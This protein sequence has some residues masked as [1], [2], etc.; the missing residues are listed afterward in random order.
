VTWWPPDDDQ[1]QDAHAVFGRGLSEEQV[2]DAAAA[3]A[4]DHESAGIRPAGVPDGFAPLATGSV[5]FDFPVLNPSTCV[6]Y[7]GPG[8]GWITLIVAEGDVRSNSWPARPC[9]ASNG[10]SAVSSGPWAGRR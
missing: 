5:H 6:R 7:E 10:R 1:E 2:L 3:A 4:I 8:G 9:A